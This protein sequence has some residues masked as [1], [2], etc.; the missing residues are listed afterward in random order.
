M[1]ILPCVPNGCLSARLAPSCMRIGHEPFGTQAP[2]FTLTSLTCE[3][4]AVNAYDKTF[5]YL[6]GKNILSPSVSSAWRAF[7]AKQPLNAVGPLRS[8]GSGSA[9]EHRNRFQQIFPSQTQERHGIFSAGQRELHAHT[10][11]KPFHNFRQR[12]AGTRVSS[13]EIALRFAGKRQK[14]RL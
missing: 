8:T 9:I 14:L 2:P 11:V 12:R 5:I 6:T 10:G 3:C 1:K 13:G 4:F 7:S